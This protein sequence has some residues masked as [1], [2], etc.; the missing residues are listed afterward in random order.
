MMP[1]NPPKPTGASVASSLADADASAKASPSADA[2]VGTIQDCLD[3]AP[4]I[5]PVAPAAP[6]VLTEA[7]AQAWFDKFRARE[8][9]PW[10]YPNDCCYTRAQVM[11]AELRQAGVEV[12]KAW[13][14]APSIDQPLRV[15]TPNDPKGYVNWG[16]HVAPV[17]KVSDGVDGAAWR[18]IDP[19][20]A[21]H[22]ITQYEWKVMQGQQGSTLVQTTDAPYYRAPDGREIP[23]PGD[24]QVQ[25]TFADHKRARAANWPVP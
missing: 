16:Y 18:V 1:P 9:I 11:A 13:N 25:E 5:A 2:S 22:P 4:A 10:D 17:V 15:N 8:N 21:S 20:I 6:K 14:Y 12:G 24:A 23:A 19:S 7:E 3:A